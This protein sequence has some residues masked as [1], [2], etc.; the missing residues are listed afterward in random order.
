MGQKNEPHATFRDWVLKALDAHGDRRRGVHGYPVPLDGGLYATQLGRFLDIFPRNQVRVYLYESYRADPHAV[1]RDILAFLG[2]DPNYPID[3]SQRHNE[4]LVPRF[5]T[6][7][8]LRQQI[9]RNVPLIAW[10]PAPAGNALKKLSHR[11]RSSFVMDPDARRL[12]VDYYRDEI[13]RTEGLI[14]TDLSAWLR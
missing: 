5:P 12:V 4:T 7:A 2:V 11:R 14:G 8:R 9:L 3:V 13:L 10:L 1:L 6:I